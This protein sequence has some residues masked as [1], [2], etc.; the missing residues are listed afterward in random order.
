MKHNPCSR[1][2]EITTEHIFI[3]GQKVS[4][5]RYHLVGSQ[6]DVLIDHEDTLPATLDGKV[7]EYVLQPETWA[8]VSAARQTE[9]SR[10]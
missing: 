10:V 4:P 9:L 3:A 1:L 7:A 5:G 2:P 8:E 6:R